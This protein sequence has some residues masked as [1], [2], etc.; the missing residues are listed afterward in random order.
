MVVLLDST[1]VLVCSVVTVFLLISTCV[2][3][4][5]CTFDFLSPY[6]SISPGLYI[7]DQTGI[8][9]LQCCVTFEKFQISC[10]HSRVYVATLF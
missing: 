7:L 9:L 3:E 10:L 4:M 1:Y 6:L 8:S 2:L 5:L